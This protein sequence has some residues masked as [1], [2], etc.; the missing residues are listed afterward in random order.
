[1]KKSS[2]DDELES[3]SKTAAL[4]YKASKRYLDYLSGVAKE[5][6]NQ[7]KEIQDLTSVRLNGTRKV[8]DE[9]SAYGDDVNRMSEYLL[10]TYRTIVDREKGIPEQKNEKLS[11]I[12]EDIIDVLPPAGLLSYIPEGSVDRFAEIAN[13]GMHLEQVVMGLLLQS[14]PELAQERLLE[15]PGD[16]EDLSLDKYALIYVEVVSDS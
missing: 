13:A 16:N 10:D 5:K 9:N 4:M 14:A 8:A 2:Y 6:S 1:M 11:G 7:V 12:A 3:C 15:S